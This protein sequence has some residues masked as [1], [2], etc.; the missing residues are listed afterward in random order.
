VSELPPD[1]RTPAPLHPTVRWLLL[2]LA[3]LCLALAV[4]G[5]FLPVVPTV[6]FLVLAAWAATRSSPR[7]ARWLE[8]H[9]LLGPPLRDWRHGGVVRRRAKWLATGMM[10]ASV[11]GLLVVL[12]PSWQVAAI[13]AV[14][15]AVALWLWQRPEQAP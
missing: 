9:P 14:M 12:G 8:N 15:A 1:T 4:I 3:A 7:L 10:S 6:P 13:A 2:L 5:L 11:T